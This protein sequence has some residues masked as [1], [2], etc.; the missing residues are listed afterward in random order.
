VGTR[1]APDDR[2]AVDP[3]VMVVTGASRGIGAG[4]A[5]FAA[6]RGLR[7]GLCARTVPAAPAES[8]AVVASVD[9]GDPAAVDGFA[10]DVVDRFG[11]IDLWVNNAGVLG[12]I[13]PLAD[14]DPGAL[15]RHME[16]NVLGVVHGSAAFARHVRAR[17]G[18]GSLVNVSS[19]AATSPYRGWAVYC[20]SKAA[21]EM[22]TEVVG[23]E[24]RGAG[25]LAYAVA[26]GVVD[27]DMQALIRSTP[28]GSFPDVDRF[29][30]LADEGAFATADWVAAWILERCLD[31]ATRWEP[32]EGRGSVRFRVPEPPPSR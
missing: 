26:P 12:P 20:A 1:A 2:A 9:V 24:E 13:G 6:R 25:L 27:T 29:H 32:E 28:S 18:T 30:R 14:A 10:R 21:V 7:L 4:L 23:L 17:P 8:E 11:R 22:L 3:P 16:T 5:A 19:G 15:A 31:R